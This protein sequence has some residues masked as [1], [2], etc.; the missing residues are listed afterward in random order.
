MKRSSR[1]S[2]LEGHG[3]TKEKVV[4]SRDTVLLLVCTGIDEKANGACAQL[5]F[6]PVDSLFSDDICIC[7]FMKANTELRTFSNTLS[8]DVKS[9]HRHM[10]ALKEI[11][12]EHLLR[13]SGHAVLKQSICRYVHSAG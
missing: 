13:L 8:L 9:L 6:A 1:L 11:E 12:L 10:E 2:K 4:F 7:T 5:V 3:F